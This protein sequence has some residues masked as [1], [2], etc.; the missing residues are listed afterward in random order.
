MSGEKTEQPSAKRLRDARRKGQVAKS[1]DFTQ[2]ALIL[3][4]FG[5]LISAGAML[6]RS[7]TELLLMPMDVIDKPF[8]VVLDQ[9]LTQMIHDATLLMLPWLGIVIVVVILAESLQVGVLFAF[10]ALKPSGKKLNPVENAKN[11]FAKKNL[12]ELLKSLLK[13]AFIGALIYTVVRGEIVQLLTLPRAG[14]DGVGVAL[15]GLLKMVIVNVAVGYTVLA[16]ADF[17]WQR[18]SYTKGLM[19]TK[20]EVKQE[21]KEAEG[22]QHIKGA[23]KHLHQELLMSGGA[24]RTRQAS[25]VV[26]NPTHIAVALLYDP[27][28]TPLPLVLAMGADDLARR[29]R[30]EAA[31]AGVPMM[32]NVPLARALYAA[33]TVDDFVPA[34]MLEPVAEVLRVVRTLAGKGDDASEV[35]SR[36]D[37]PWPA[38]LDELRELG[39][40]DDDPPP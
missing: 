18:H 24:A 27:P 23:R 4:L 40:R 21:Y 2:T 12:V 35:S 38:D 29:I 7:M 22:D 39:V 14:L 13:I 8:R 26:T 19:M 36:A 32:E 5:Y 10:E 20:E 15:T 30:E 1:K 37:R 25:V 31:D 11:I 6:A 33:A 34:S 9:L 3:A 28:R 16:L 17:V